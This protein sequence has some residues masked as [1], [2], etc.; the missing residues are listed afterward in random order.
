MERPHD[1]GGKPAGPID[2]SER[3]LA[4]WEK[5]AHVLMGILGRELKL[6]T[7]S[8]EFIEAIPPDDYEA[9]SYYERWIASMETQLIEAGV[10]T[11]EEIDAKVREMEGA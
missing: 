10:L 5:N 4:Q 8:R 9:F 7:G 3:D 11:R 2:L 1:V 6:I